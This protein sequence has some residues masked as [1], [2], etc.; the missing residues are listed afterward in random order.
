MY[1]LYLVRGVALVI[2]SGQS[3]WELPLRPGKES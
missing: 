3:W 2:R 1:E